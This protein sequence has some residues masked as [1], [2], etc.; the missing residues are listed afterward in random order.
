MRSAS[1][2]SVLSSVLLSV[3]SGVL[4]SVL[5]CVLSSV[6]SGISEWSLSEWFLWVFLE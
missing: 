2:V 4:P 5:S 3:L 1:E 6:R